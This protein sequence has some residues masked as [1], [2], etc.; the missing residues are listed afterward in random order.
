MKEIKKA[1]IPIAG[2]GTRFLPLSK[3]IPKELWPLADVPAVQ[4]IVEEAVNSGIEKIIFV[5]DPKNKQI[6]DY[7]KPSPKIE[8]VLKSRGKK[9]ILEELKNFQERFKNISFSFVVQK[10]PMGDGHAL[11]QAKKLVGKEPVASLFADDIVDSKTPCLAQL[12]QV[13]KTCQKPVLSL[14]KLPKEEISAYGTVDIEKIASRLF[15][16]KKIIEK[17]SPEEIPSDLAMVGKHILTPE[18]FDYLKK[19]KPS[20]K[21]EIILAEVL[22]KMIR[23][24]KLI[25]GYEFEGRWLECGDKMKWLKSNLYFSLNHPR[26]GQELR[27]F[28]KDIL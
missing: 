18:V 8:R 27:A 17:P 15:K 14:Y 6:L 5:T 21:G 23:E 19:A 26:Y 4:K 1:I 3:V 10:K 22:A 11:L 9:N 2:M 13:F 25:Y 24:G 12:K 20:E 7:F 28:L 16:I